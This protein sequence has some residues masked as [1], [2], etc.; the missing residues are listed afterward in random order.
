MATKKAASIKKKAPVV[1]HVTASSSS[2]SS[3]TTAPALVKRQS[4]GNHI[5]SAL[6]SVSLWRAVAA[7][8]LGT[9]L[10][11]ATV[12]AGQGQPIFLLF[13]LTGIV[14]IFGGISGAHVNPAITLGAW[15]TR[16]IGWLRAIG[17]VLA[18][19][20]GAAVAY[21]TLNAFV[22]GAPALTEAQQAYGQ[23][24]P[25]LYAAVDIATVAGREWY[26]FF[27][28]V[29]GTTVLA[30]AIA[31]A[32]RAKEALTAAFTAGL[33][34]FIALMFVVTIAGYISASSFI[35]PAVALA[36]Q[37][38]TPSGWA[39]LVYALAPIVGGV[40]GFVLYDIWRGKATN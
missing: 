10:L 26:V 8:F 33:G 24:A 28:E 35:N 15:A 32:L 22:G 18:Q 31:H 7:E 2:K 5:E 3:V 12:I 34:I 38:F 25:S 16:R 23:S 30:F 37:A 1:H 13:A 21:F 29:L 9:F 20:L 39:Y 36:L 27:A 6:Q 14:L 40:I 19:F 4:F 11:A 17:Y